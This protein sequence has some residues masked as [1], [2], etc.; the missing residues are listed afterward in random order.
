[1]SQDLNGAVVLVT[2]SNGG[3]G[4]EFVSQALDRGAARVYASARTPRKW[5]D[6]R[7]VP[8][9]LDVT[10]SAS[11]LAAAAVAADTT[12]LVNNAGVFTLGDTLLGGSMEDIRTTFDT[13]FFG[14]IE[15]VRAFAPVLGANGGGALLDVHSVLSWLGLA[16]AYSATKAAFWS[17]TNSFRIELAGQGTQVVGLH[18]GYTDTPMIADVTDP[19]GD[20][21]DVVRAAYDGLEAGQLEV[22]ADAF[23]ASVKSALSGPVEGLYPQL[24]TVE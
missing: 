23:S 12:V 11:I 17:A 3:L 16:G 22:L 20:P 2:G 6:P 5:D 10:D 15:V 14:A 9:T 1:M 19:K 13:N 24:S 18:L 4:R 7:V 21:A 8:L